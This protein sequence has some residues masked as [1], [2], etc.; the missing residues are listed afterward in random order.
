MMTSWSTL[1]CWCRINTFRSSWIVCLIAH[2]FRCITCK[3]DHCPSFRSGWA[4][5]ILYTGSTRQS[6][7]RLMMD[8]WAP[9]RQDSDRTGRLTNYQS[10]WGGNGN[11]QVWMGTERRR[12]E[13]V[14]YATAI[15][16][17][18]GDDVICNLKFNLATTNR[19]GYRFHGHLQSFFD[20]RSQWNQERNRHLVPN[21]PGYI[22]DINK[23][24]VV[25]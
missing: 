14:N 12:T 20:D 25:Y 24:Y 18:A 23:L 5:S 22:H 10:S 8:R 17:N 3:I 13:Q 4:A 21:R 15:E 2:Y 19:I 7:Q 11:E 6:A 16:W 1:G 9:H